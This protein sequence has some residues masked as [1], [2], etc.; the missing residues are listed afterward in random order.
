MSNN[1]KSN[2]YTLCPHKLID[3]EYCNKCGAIYY[4]NVFKTYNFIFRN[5]L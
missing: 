5:F 3:Y 1:T 2:H 4:Q